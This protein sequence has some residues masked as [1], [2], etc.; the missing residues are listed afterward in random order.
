MAVI[1]ETRGLSKRFGAIA[2]V[3]DITVS[4]ESDTVVGLNGANGAAKPA[5]PAAEAAPAPAAQTSHDITVTRR[6]YRSGESEYLI[7]G[8]PA[9]LRDIQDLFMG[10]GLGPESYAI[11]EQGR[12]GQLLSSRPQDR[13]AVL[14]EAS[15]ISRFK[16][17]RK[18][19]EARLEGAKHNLERV[20]DILE[21]VSRQ[22]NSLKRQAAKAKRYTELKGEMDTLLRRLLAGRYQML[23]R[24]TAR[25]ALDLN[26]AASG[27]QSLT[28]EAAAKEQEYSKSQVRDT[29]RRP[30][31]P[32]RA[33]SSPRSTWNWSVRG[34]SWSSR[35]S[36]SPR[37][38]SGSARASA[39]PRNSRCGCSGS[40]KSPKRTRNASRNWTSRVRRAASGW[41]R[42]TVSAMPQGWRS[43]SASAR[44]RARGSRCSACSAR[45][46]L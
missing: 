20:F 4:V 8:R 10:T 45:P 27:V 15:G 16:N 6:L 28:A 36:R 22:V 30:S 23:E 43:S 35:R 14:E 24:E 26:L 33:R 29:T 9:R 11:I 46:R 7:N 1:L 3:D 40:T 31:S 25:I 17:R 18:L 39:N 44:W 21:E 13:R 32:K 5:E 34:A 42:R 41:R 12:I 19:A 37:P 2:A 38:S